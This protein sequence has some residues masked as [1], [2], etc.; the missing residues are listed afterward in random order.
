MNL[1]EGK[2]I[3]SYQLRVSTILDF[4]TSQL[5]VASRFKSSSNSKCVTATTA[6]YNFSSSFFIFGGEEKKVQ[7]ER[8]FLFLRFCVHKSKGKNLTRKEE[9]ENIQKIIILRA[10]T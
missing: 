3:K 6:N 8:F 4:V 7:Q 9:D 10:H 2:E 5:R 1:N